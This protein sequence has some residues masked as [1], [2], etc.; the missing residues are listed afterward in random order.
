LTSIL[1]WKITLPSFKETSS[2]LEKVNIKLRES[3]IS[4]DVEACLC[5]RYSILISSL[6]KVLR[7]AEV[8]LDKTNTRSDHQG[9]GAELIEDETKPQPLNFNTINNN[10]IGMNEKIQQQS[11]SRQ[12][13]P[14]AQ[15]AFELNWPSIEDLQSVSFPSSSDLSRVRPRSFYR[16]L[17][18]G[19]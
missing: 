5:L 13:T 15:Q 14:L 4:D 7:E 12:L 16:F 8:H 3:A 17:S 10:G 1:Q 9:C 19:K 6:T 18:V 11:Q 2:L